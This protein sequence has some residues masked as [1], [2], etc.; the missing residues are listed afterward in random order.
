MNYAELKADLFAALDKKTSWGR[1]ELKIVIDDVF[2]AAADKELA[3][4]EQAPEKRVEIGTVAWPE[5]AH[6]GDPYDGD[7]D[8]PWR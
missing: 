6:V 3:R 5:Y 2:L 7:N 4:K 8:V 1:N